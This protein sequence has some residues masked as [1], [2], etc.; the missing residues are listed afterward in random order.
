MTGFTDKPDV[1]GI[2]VA[3]LSHWKDE[4]FKLQR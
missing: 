4:V 1:R 3:D 2:E